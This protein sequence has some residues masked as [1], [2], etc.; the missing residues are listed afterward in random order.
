[1][2]I[3]LIH[4]E[5]DYTGVVRGV[6]FV[7]G[8]GTTSSPHDAVMFIGEGYTVEDPSAREVVRGLARNLAEQRRKRRAEYEKQ[9]QF[10]ATAAYTESALRRKAEREEQEKKQ[11]HRPARRR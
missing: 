10:E 6:D 5:P 4:P 11:C 3:V 9:R 1:M 2:I 8:R 7:K